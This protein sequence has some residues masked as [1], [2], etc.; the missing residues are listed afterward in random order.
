M[1]LTMFYV[2]KANH[3]SACSP[4][5]CYYVSGC[6]PIKGQNIF[7]VLHNNKTHNWWLVLINYYKIKDIDRYSRFPGLGTLNVSHL[8]HPRHFNTIYLVSGW[9]PRPFTRPQPVGQG[10]W[11]PQRIAGSHMS[12]SP[13]VPC[14]WNPTDQARAWRWEIA[15]DDFMVLMW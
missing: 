3:M 10:S 9:V 6:N 1:T 8:Q 13:M 4:S 15:N 14:H 7:L 12:P 2:M 5:E 11:L